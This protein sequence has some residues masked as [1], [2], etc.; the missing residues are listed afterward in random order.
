MYLGPLWDFVRAREEELVAREEELAAKKLES[1]AT[2]ESE[3]RQKVESITL[4]DILTVLN[5]VS[6]SEYHVGLLRFEAINGTP[7]E[8]T[9]SPDRVHLSGHEDLINAE[10][11]GNEI[12][13]FYLKKVE[14]YEEREKNESPPF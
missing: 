8:A 10:F 6:P 4:K 1:R 14:E 3:V 13:P 5:N 7:Y 9:V 11:R 2:F 12:R